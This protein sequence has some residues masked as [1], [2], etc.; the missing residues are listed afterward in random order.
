MNKLAIQGG[1][2]VISEALPAWPSLDVSV[3]SD[4]ESI[5]QTGE[6]N[7]WTGKRGMAFEKDLAD[8]LGEGYVVTTTNGTSALHTAFAALGIGSGDEVICQSYTFIA[9]AFSVLQAGALPVF[10]D[11]DHTHTLDPVSV[12]S[13]IT[14]KTKA[15]VVV[16]T[17]GVATDMDAIMAIAKKFDLRVIEDCAQA[18]GSQYKGAYLG[19]IGDVGCFSFCQSKHITTGGEG[20]AVYV[21]SEDLVWKCRSFRDH[22]YDVEKR[23]GLFE[24]SQK[25]PYIHT[26]VG[27]NYRMTEIQ[28]AIGIR[29]LA[30]FRE[31]ALAQ[32][33]RN[34]RFLSALLQEHPLVKHAPVDD[35]IRVNSFWWAPFVL[36]M[37]LLNC[38]IKTFTQALDAEGVPGYP[39]PWP[40]VYNEAAFQ[41]QN[42]FG[43]KNYPFNDPAHRQMDY[44]RTDCPA[45][46]HFGNTS[47]VFHTHPVYTEQ[48]MSH[49]ATA[50]NKVYEYYKK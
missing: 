48:H 29:E 11:V 13:K 34:G 16:H 46:R 4:I 39:V 50:L 14:E 10:A 42:G 1:T 26:Q 5:L 23:L 28:S 40:E 27:F 6:I 44:T 43:E 17:F 7:Y 45:A 22:G 9:T 24:I 33:V 25:L 38:D 47:I 3:M 15:I 36:D 49:F 41:Q 32:R 19:T 37:S 12:E 21:N 8:F 2:P 30:R 18:L 31:T 35:E 20:G